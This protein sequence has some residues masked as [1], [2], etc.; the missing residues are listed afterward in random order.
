MANFR[1]LPQI[2][3]V[4][5]TNTAGYRGRLVYHYKTA[6]QLTLRNNNS[7]H[8]CPYERRCVRVYAME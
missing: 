7:A 2:A 3:H 1:V 8:K 6:N 4:L 5:Y